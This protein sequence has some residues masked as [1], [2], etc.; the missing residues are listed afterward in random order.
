MNLRRITS[1]TALLA[2]A[3]LIVTSIILYIVPAGRV[4][5]WA[6]WSLWGLSKEQ[7]AAVHINLGFL[8]LLCMILHLYYNWAALLS[9]LK[10]RARQLRI[11]TPEFNMALLVTL[12]VCGGT[13][14]GIPPMSSLIHLGEDLSERG[15]L[16]YG[17]P[18]YGH[19]E[20]S[21]LAD[22][23]DKVGVELDQALKALRDGGI[24]V[25]S[26]QQTLQEL[27]AEHD[28]SPQQIYLLIKPAPSPDGATVM[29]EEAP[30]GTGKRTLAQ[31]CEIYQL[32]QEQV[33]NELRQ[34]GIAAESNQTMKDIA[35]ANSL[36]PH[37]LYG[38]IYQISQH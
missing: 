18:P 32:N 2:F 36:D 25:A 27:A 13:L 29:P 20:L 1:L 34:Q 8:L 33:L 38:L 21:P 9:Y 30:G 17:E 24:R 22:F 15:N 11:L 28:T 31:I 5:Y 19:A 10:N 4:A 37:G 12:I 35:A 3:L 7:W 14:A 16:K 6:G 23:A 26:E